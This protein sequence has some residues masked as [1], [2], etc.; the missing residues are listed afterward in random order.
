[1]WLNKEQITCLTTSPS[2]LNQLLQ[3]FTLPN[4]VKVIGLGG[5]SVTEDLLKQLI[6]NTNIQKIFNFYGPTE[7]T[8]GICSGIIYRKS[9]KIAQ[10]HH[11]FSGVIDESITS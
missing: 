5:E 6:Q 2:V 10:T 1:M 7:A 3:N 4:C 9:E 11:K 8:I